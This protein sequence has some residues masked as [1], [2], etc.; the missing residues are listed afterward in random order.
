MFDVV[1][2]VVNRVMCGPSSISLGFFFEIH[3]TRYV[4]IL[5]SYII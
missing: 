3:D 4:E 1:L 5:W 2:T